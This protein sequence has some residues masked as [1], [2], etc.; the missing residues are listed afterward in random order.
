M[1]AIS[2]PFT[3]LLFPELPG[4]I[5]MAAAFGGFVLLVQF[6]VDFENRLEKVER[7]LVSSVDEMRKSVD[8]GFAKVNSATALLAQVETAGLRTL[9]VTQL[10]QHAGQISPHTPPLVAML[11]EAELDRVSEFLRGLAK[12]EAN[13]DG[14]D[15]AW[16]LE[17]T[18][19]ANRSIDAIS[20]PEVDA[21]GNSLHSFWES[22]LGR[23]YLDCQRKAV[24]RGIRV[25]R[26]FV[27]DYDK[28][29][30][31][32]VLQHICRTQAEVGIEVRLLYPTSAPRVLQGYLFD[33]IVFDN[34]L[35][36]EVTAAAHVEQGESPMILNTRLVMRTDL[37][38]ERID[39]YRNIWDSAVPWSDPELETREP[40]SIA[41][42]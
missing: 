40:V 29:R 12:Q 37:V 8:E 9:A 38:A 26:V 31:D 4:Q 22:P 18:N 39:R 42:P 34:T 24:Q 35:S 10:M 36:Y 41:L 7:Q 19:C 13:Y 21:A 3:Q 30:G 11:A 23:Q 27:T 25:R 28:L 20:L 1:G 2:F 15:H 5:T 17:L 33:F 14:E 6:L 16:L 32:P